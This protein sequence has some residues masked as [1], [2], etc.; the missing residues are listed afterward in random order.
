MDNFRAE[1]FEDPADYEEGPLRDRKVDFPN[2]Q[3]RAGKPDKKAEFIRDVIALANTARLWGKP[4]YLLFGIDDSGRVAGIHDYLKVFDKS[5][6]HQVQEEARK[7]VGSL[8][9]E[10]VKPIMARFDLKFG[11]IHG[12]LVAYLLLEPLLSPEPFQVAKSFG[13]GMKRPLKESECWIRFGESKNK[14]SAREIS[15][16]EEPFCYTYAQVP[17]LLP[18]QWER[19]FRTVLNDRALHEADAISYYLE[20][21]T[22]V[23]KRLVSAVGTFLDSDEQRLLLIRGAAG[24]GKSTFLER[25]VYQYASDGQVSIEGIRQREEFMPPPDWI[26]VLVRLRHRDEN[27]KSVRQFT[28]YLM[29][30]IGAQGEFWKERPSCPE[31][32]LELDAVRWLLCLDGYDELEESGQ[33]KFFAMISEFVRRYPQTKVL[34]TSRPYTIQVDWSGTVDAAIETIRP[35]TDREIQEFLETYAGRHQSGPTASENAALEDARRD[36]LDF[37]GSHPDVRKLCSYPSYLAATIREFFPISYDTPADQPES[38]LQSRSADLSEALDTAL[39]SADKSTFSPLVAEDELRLEAPVTEELSEVEAFDGENEDPGREIQTGIILDNIYQYLWQREAHRWSVQP[40]ASSE[41][42]AET[43]HL[44]LRMHD[45]ITFSP[46]EA[47]R[48]IGSLPKWLLTLGICQATATMPINLW[49]V[50]ELTKAFFA[51]SV[52]ANCHDLKSAEQRLW[53]CTQ[54]FRNQVWNLLDSLTPHDFSRS[55]QEESEWHECHK[56]T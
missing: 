30:V 31:K 49:F 43:G 34:L 5:E 55:F 6:P 22:T 20:P 24:S 13:K 1:L 35:L 53:E 51:A 21:T 8:I 46:R 2:L 56:Q 47:Q 28:E 38:V 48:T 29:T 39:Q 18:S 12:H 33:K 32:L 45:R 52:L 4:A 17:Y 26:P 27:V 50:T 44:A 54:R 7:Q 41:R 3:K 19:Y 23:G 16:T 14:I 10:Y 25:L 9:K 15:P 40:L 37:V 36:A 11:Q 42:W